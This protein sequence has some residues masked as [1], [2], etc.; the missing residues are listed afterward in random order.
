MNECKPLVMGR[1]TN[2]TLDR[3][4][5]MPGSG[6]PGV[7]PSDSPRSNSGDNR[8]A[9][10]PA[11]SVQP[12]NAGDFDAMG[13]FR[14]AYEVGWCKS[15][16][17]DPLLTCVE[18]AMSSGAALKAKMTNRFRTLHSSSTCGFTTRMIRSRVRGCQ[19]PMDQPGAGATRQG[20]LLRTGTRPH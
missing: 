9:T 17:V 12:M 20:G 7:P 13:S 4:A 11:D 5:S 8:F 16:Q 2:T 18:R 6:L 14:A 3:A 1:A 10:I 19:A 15:T